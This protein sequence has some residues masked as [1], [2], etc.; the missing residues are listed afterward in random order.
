MFQN[1]LIQA[2]FGLLNRFLIEPIPYIP[3]KEYLKRVLGIG[4]KAAEK[5]TDSNPENKEQLAELWEQEHFM[6]VGDSYVF[7]DTAVIEKVPYAPLRIYM[8]KQLDLMQAV[9]AAI[10]DT[11]PNDME[12]LKAIWE[13]QKGEFLEETAEAVVLAIPD[14]IE[15]EILASTIITLIQAGLNDL[16]DGDGDD[17]KPSRPLLKGITDEKQT[18]TDIA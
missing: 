5:L 15:D 10:V 18:S 16:I 13:N 3:L 1:I 2:A 7:L 4:K 14:L 6:F 12:Q 8:Q 11:N 17:P 9:T